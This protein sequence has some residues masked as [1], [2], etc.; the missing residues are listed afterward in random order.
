MGS[1]LGKSFVMAHVTAVLLHAK[2]IDSVTIIFSEQEL[3]DN[4]S[5]IIAKIKELCSGTVITK[6]MNGNE[7]IVLAA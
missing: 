7:H 4:E 5:T 3:L 1:G 6:I 2:V